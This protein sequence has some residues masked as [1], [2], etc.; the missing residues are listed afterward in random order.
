MDWLSSFKQKQWARVSSL[1]SKE[2]IAVLA[3][4]AD[5]PL[6]ELLGQGGVRSAVYRRLSRPEAHS[7]RQAESR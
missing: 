6:D 1:L 5:F 7:R 4:E 3:E 2:E